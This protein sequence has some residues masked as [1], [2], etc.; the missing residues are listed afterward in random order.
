MSKAKKN[1]IKKMKE[2]YG[3]QD[4]EEREMRLT[5][6]GAKKV[7]DFDIAQHQE[8]KHKFTKEESEPEEDQPADDLPEEEE[9]IEQVQ[10]DE[11][12]DINMLQNQKE[13]IDPD[14]IIEEAGEE[15]DGKDEDETEA[16]DIQQILKDED[17]NLVP[18]DQ[19]VSEIDKLTGVPTR[20][21]TLL[22]AL[23][24]LAPYST[25]QNM[26]YKV[27]ITPG[28]Q[29][30]GRVQKVIKELYHKIAKDSKIETQLLKSINDQ[31]MTM[32]LVNNCKVAAA[33]LTAIQ[34][35]QKKDKKS[36]PKP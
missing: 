25:I 15:G 4:E 36:Q 17:I 3:D 14:A 29:K 28:T 32:V 21:D 8:K 6:L 24:M 27:K 1:K 2:K 10:V 16:K 22:F 26:K 23:P 5:L 35:Q 18:E 31:D 7:K 12:L 34:Q 30:R 11:E 9:K 13:D 19:D 33:G 20:K